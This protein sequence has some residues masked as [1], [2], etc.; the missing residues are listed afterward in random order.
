MAHLSHH[1]TYSGQQVYSGEKSNSLAPSL[2]KSF[3][4]EFIILNGGNISHD[5]W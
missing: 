1:H 4:Y 3:A 2:S 5:S